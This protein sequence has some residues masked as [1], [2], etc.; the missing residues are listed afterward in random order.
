M[1]A[2]LSIMAAQIVAIIVAEHARTVVRKVAGG[3]AIGR[4]TNEDPTILF[5]I[6]VVIMC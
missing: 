5:L 3:R 1:P 4:T 6:V 2:Q